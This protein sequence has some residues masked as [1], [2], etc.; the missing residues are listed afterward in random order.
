MQGWHEHL[1]KVAILLAMI[2]FLATFAISYQSAG[3]AEGLSVGEMELDEFKASIGD[4]S[5][6]HFAADGEGTYIRFARD[7]GLMAWL[8]G[9]ATLSMLAGRF[10]KHGQITLAGL[11]AAIVSLLFIL[12]KLR[13]LIRDKAI[14]EHYFWEAPRNAFA[15]S[16]VAYDWI[17][18]GISLSMMVCL[19]T[20]LILRRPAA[21]STY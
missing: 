4:T 5:K 21:R 11:V 6:V 16:T 9:V 17:L 13:L 10:Q 18:V 15:H 8:F 19:A 3:L 20:A 12:Y 7:Y 14:V 1:S 2:G